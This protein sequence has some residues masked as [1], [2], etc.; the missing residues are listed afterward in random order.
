MLLLKDFIE[1]LNFEDIKK[2]HLG[3]YF[4]MD[5]DHEGNRDCWFNKT[6]N[7]CC[8]GCFKITEKM[9]G[10]TFMRKIVKIH[11]EMDKIEEIQRNLTITAEDLKEIYWKHYFSA[12]SGSMIIYL[13]Q[14]EYGEYYTDTCY[15]KDD[16]VIDTISVPIENILNTDGVLYQLSTQACKDIMNDE[17]N[18]HQFADWEL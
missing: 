14:D 11:K 18:Y 1:N 2:K 15:T 9:N 13:L 7:D 3:D 16:A 10:S 4:Y 12:N 8:I 17:Y 5:F 6:E